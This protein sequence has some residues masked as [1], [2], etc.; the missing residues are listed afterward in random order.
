MKLSP[1]LVLGTPSPNV[2]TITIGR[3]EL[4]SSTSAASSMYVSL[5]STLDLPLAP[6]LTARTMVVSAIV[7]GPVYS[8][9]PAV[10]TDSLS[11]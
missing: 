10:G 3:F 9:E 8:V 6:T 1:K 4:S 11:V 7:S 2:S 5:T